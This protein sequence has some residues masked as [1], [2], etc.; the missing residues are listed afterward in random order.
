MDKQF[1]L[2]DVSVTII[3]AGA[4]L[5]ASAG[6]VIEGDFFQMEKENK[7][8]T[9]TRRGTKGETYSANSAE[10]K[11][12]M[13]TLTYLPT[14]LAVKELDALMKAKEKFG[15]SVKCNAE[16]KFTFFSS[17]CNITEEPTVKI[18]GKDGFDNKEFKIRALDSEYVY[19]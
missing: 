15:L 3:K 16:P 11:S 4:P 19:L 9:N 7:T 12:R 10:D 8:E 6:L 13:V 1:N 14:A 18:N 17:V 5:D 2:D